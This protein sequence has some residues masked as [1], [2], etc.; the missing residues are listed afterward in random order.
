ML[1]TC[2]AGW[3]SIEI[4][5]ILAY[6]F[7]GCFLVM[8]LSYGM[9]SSNREKCGKGMVKYHLLFKFFFNPLYLIVMIL[10]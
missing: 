2:I 1:F 9:T 10:I 5:F 7:S 3:Y 4:D 8:V 6:H